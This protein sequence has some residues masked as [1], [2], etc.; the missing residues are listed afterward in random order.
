MIDH[1]KLVNT[2]SSAASINTN[3]RQRSHSRGNTSGS[4][5]DLSIGEE[6][7]IIEKE[8]DTS[9]SPKLEG[10]GSVTNLAS[11]GSKKVKF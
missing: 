5:T 7:S 10:K 8:K 6:D 11:S 4:R 9:V 2:Q 1:E 3:G